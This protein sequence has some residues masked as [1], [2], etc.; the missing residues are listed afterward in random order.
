MGPNKISGL[1]AHILLV[2]LVLAAVPV[3]ALLLVLAGVWPA[4]RRR[5]G[6]ITPV[7]A[8]GALLTVPVTT[9]AGHWLQARVAM[10]P[11]IRKH[12][13]LGSRVLPWMIA[14]FVVA[15]LVWAWDRAGRAAGRSRAG[16]S[17]A[18]RSG[19]GAGCTAR[20]GGLSSL[21]SPSPCRLGRCSRSSAPARLA[22]AQSGPETT[23]RSR[24][25]GN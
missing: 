23:A 11:L 20:S 7:I 9:H 17:G 15:V 18:G 6:I 4:A 12:V 25:N 13:A 10:T 19:T 16:R 3:A 8:L 24:S 21:S 14:L 1:P 5:L 22:R 2:H